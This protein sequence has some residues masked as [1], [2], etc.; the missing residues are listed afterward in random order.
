MK[1]NERL[2][3]A[4]PSTHN[5][6]WAMSDSFLTLHLGSIKKHLLEE[7][8]S[9]TYHRVLTK[10]Y[11]V[12]HDEFFKMMGSLGTVYGYSWLIWVLT[13]DC[14]LE[15]TIDSDNGEQIEIMPYNIRIV[16]RPDFNFETIID[17]F[18]PFISK[19]KQAQIDWAFLTAQGLK[20]HS[21]MSPLTEEIR[22]QSYPNI[23]GI[24]EYAKRFLESSENLLLLQGSPGTGK[25]RF[26]RHVIKSINKDCPKVLYSME[27]Q[28]FSSEEFFIK[29]FVDN[30]DLLVLED[31]DFHLKSRKDGNSFMY[32]LLGGTDGFIQKPR[33]MILSTNL[34]S[35]GEI[36]AALLRPGR[37]F[38]VKQF[39]KLSFNEAVELCKVE[40]ISI[41]LLKEH[42]EYTLADVY[43]LKRRNS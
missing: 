37:C 3:L 41:D 25:T 8:K 7:S 43:S 14:L 24:D 40:N 10:S 4:V 29:F 42:S 38:D 16:A 18:E 15:V 35:V 5:Y 17:L 36:D 19:K 13:K 12:N 28:A 6:L 11:V 31:I 23:D 22:P 1:V 27:E 9:F 32:K 34:P 21:I 33:K 2:P 30:Y 20:Y 39:R 26:I